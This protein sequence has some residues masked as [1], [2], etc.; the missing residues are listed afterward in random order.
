VTLIVEVAVLVHPPAPVTVTVYVVVAD[1]KA[2]TV[3]PVLIERSPEGL[4]E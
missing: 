2:I 3:V 4:Q 1:G